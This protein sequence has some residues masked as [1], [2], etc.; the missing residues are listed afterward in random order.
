[1]HFKC[2]SADPLYQMQKICRHSRE[3]GNPDPSARKFIE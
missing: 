1:M 3:R 2:E